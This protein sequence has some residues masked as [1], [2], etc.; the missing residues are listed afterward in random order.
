MK[1][2]SIVLTFNILFL[3]VAPS[4]LVILPIGTT[5]CEMSC[6]AH[7]GKKNLPKECNGMGNPF[8]SCC[9]IFALTAEPTGLYTAITNSNQD[10]GSTI[11]KPCF[12]FLSD[13]WRPP[14]V[15]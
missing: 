2:F 8:M 9:N 10:F 7:E 12:D 6:C 3:T 15:V 1:L 5:H 11:E 4:L 13:A 14:K